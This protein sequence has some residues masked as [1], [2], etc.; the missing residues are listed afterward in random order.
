M[1]KCWNFIINHVIDIIFI[2]LIFYYLFACSYYMHFDP[3]Y[4]CIAVIPI[5]LII[6][7][8]LFNYLLKIQN[9]NEKKL[10]LIIVLFSLGIYIIWELF[11]NTP[12]LSDYKVLWDAAGDFANGTFSKMTFIKNNYFYV[13]NHQIGYVVLLG[14]IVKVI[15]HHLLLVKIVEFLMLAFSNLFVYNIAKKIVSPKVGLMSTIIYTTLLFNIGGAGILNNQHMAVFFMLWGINILLNKKSVLRC[16]VCSVF[17]AIAFIARPTAIIFFIALVAYLIWKFL[18]DINLKNF[19]KISIGLLLVVLPFIITLKTYDYIL[20]N[21][22]MVPDSALKT[23]CSYFKFILGVQWQNMHGESPWDDLDYYNFDYEKYNIAAKNY[24]TSK[25]K[26]HFTTEVLPFWYE[27]MIRFSGYPDS[28]IDFAGINEKSIVGNMIKYYGY[29]EYL[30]CL[31]AILGSLIILK[32]KKYDKLTFF[33]ILFIGFFFAHI[34]VEV[35]PRYRFEQY[36]AIAILA[37]PLLVWLNDKFKDRIVKNFKNIYN[38]LINYK[39]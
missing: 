14:S 37:S 2:I 7:F 3:S 1:K 16:I 30:L 28:Q 33:K 21:T 24:V 12:Q 31:M 19:K 4:K 26:N 20:I 35:Q 18:I 39:L 38:S 9:K 34:L 29:A 10:K 11:N 13:W 25:Y 17:F 15:G 32:T 8:V 22:K 27:K 5:I 6:Y 23:H 36:T